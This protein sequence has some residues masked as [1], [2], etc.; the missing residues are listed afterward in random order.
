MM[1]NSE[2]ERWSGR[3]AFIMAAIGSAVGLGNLWRF[4]AQ[5]FQ[6]GGGAFFIPYFVALISAGF[7][8]VIVEYALGQRYQGG[9]PKALAAVTRK[10]KWVGWFALFVG[11]VIV[12]YYVVVMG[13]AW[14][15][16]VGALSMAWTKPASY[17]EV[18]QES[19]GDISATRIPADQIQVCLRAPDEESAERMD[20]AQEKRKKSDR[21]PVYQADELEQLRAE[22]ADVD[23]AERTY[24]VTLS[25]NVGNYFNETVLGGFRPELWG[26][27]QG[28]RDLKEE[29]GEAEDAGEPAAAAEARDRA[30]QLEG[31]LSPHRREMFSL[32]APLILGT[33][34]TWILIFLI[35]FKGVRNVGKVVMLTVPVPVVLIIV[36][37]IRGVTLPGAAEGLLYYLRPD[38]EML[39]NPTVWVR[40]YGQIFFSLT[41]GFGVL[42]AY[43]SYMPRES[44]VTNSA[45]ITSFGNCATSFIAGLAVFSV[46]GYMAYVQGSDVE[47]LAEQGIGGPGLVFVTYPIALAQMP[48]GLVATSALSLIFFLCLVTLGIDSAFSLVEGI[49]TGFRDHLPHVSKAT[50]TAIFCVVGFAG[51]LFICTDS[52]LMWLDILDNWMSSYGLVLV[53]LLECIA[54]GYF[55]HISDLK[56]YIN[57]HSEIQVHH[58]FDVFIKFVTPAILILLLGRQFLGDMTETYEGYDSILPHAVNI[59]GWGVLFLIFVLSLIAAR[60]WKILI[61]TLSVLVVTVLAYAY[62]SVAMFEPSVGEIMPAAFM[63][64]L[65]VSLLFG[66]VISGILIARRT[67]HM[68]GLSLEATD[69]QGE[70]KEG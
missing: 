55:F 18:E 23:P 20:E 8:L 66:G 10:F 7:P 59:G 13:Y 54:V 49:V 27:Y 37:V 40:A 9:A 22:Q 63:C 69:E 19:D 26:A 14:R 31:K 35:I 46:V 29:A 33:A 58:W 60:S 17:M 45:L 43:A 15:Y 53:G 25:E 24:Y 50:L 65:A 67:H 44:D 30:E 3:M 70:E 52:G 12:M 56:Q 51:S 21:L 36:M 42:I 32:N 4:P 39:M 38:W 64:G 28:V 2:R 41:L 57:T 48:M 11:S 34:L 5:A 1:D 62:F 16:S 68:A 61:W 47:A 6:N